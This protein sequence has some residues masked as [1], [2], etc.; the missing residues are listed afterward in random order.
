MT[1]TTTRPEATGAARASLLPEGWLRA[2]VAALEAALLGWLVCVVPAIAAYVA[3]AASPALGDSTWQSGLGIGSAAWLLGHGAPAGSLSLVPLGLSAVLAALVMGTAR[4]H[5]LRGGA[6]VVVALGYV[7]LVQLVSLLSPFA[8]DHVRLA[9]GSAV[10]AAAGCAWSWWRTGARTRDLIEDDAAGA[11]SDRFTHRAGLVGVRAL[12][13]AGATL[14]VL[15]VVGLAA[16]VAAIALH[17]DRVLALHESYDAGIVGGTV[18]VLGQLAYLPTLGV[19][20]FAYVAGPGFAVGTG[21][22]VGHGGVELGAVP[23]IPLLG[24]LPESPSPL[25]IWPT[26]LVVLAGAVGA[27]W[28]CRPGHAHRLLDAV[29]SALGAALL[30]GVATLLAGLVS[31][32][33]IGSGRMAD[34]GPDALVLAGLVTGEVALG[35]VLVATLLHPRTRTA[36]AGGVGSV[37]ER[38]ERTDGTTDEA[39]DDDT[40]SDDDT[41]GSRPGTAASGDD[42]PGG[43]ASG[44]GARAGAAGE[45]GATGTTGGTATSGAKGAGSAKGGT[46]AGTAAGSTGAGSAKSGT[47]TGTG[48]GATATRT[49]SAAQGNASR[50]GRWSAT[51]SM[52]SATPTRRAYGHGATA[53]GTAG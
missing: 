50:S 38:L 12:R 44:G 26:L 43:G 8:V 1:A 2:L 34:L 5:V 20:A 48:S 4:R 29:A 39:P 42:T 49:A 27:W 31:A 13:G 18:L 23:A 9:V 28:M 36:L 35:A 7:V 22:A 10:V 25:G 53:S 19:W 46:G 32:G 52:A 41:R 51:G 21:T 3:T 45:S 47:R 40:P 16:A 14:A 15:V 33:A 37:R 6:H 17:A 11:P 30:V 24:A